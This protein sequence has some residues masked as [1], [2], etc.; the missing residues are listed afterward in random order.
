MEEEI[1]GWFLSVGRSVLSSFTNFY[2]RS[3]DFQKILSK[4]KN[5]SFA[6]ELKNYYWLLRKTAALIKIQT[7][8][9]ETSSALLQFL[10]LFTDITE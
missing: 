7:S 6:V 3:H 1:R 4:S 9:Q 2:F 8:Y 5:L 10:A